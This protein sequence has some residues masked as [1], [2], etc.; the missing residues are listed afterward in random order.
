MYAAWTRGDDAGT[1]ACRDARI[2]EIV[3]RDLGFEGSASRGQNRVDQAHTGTCHTGSFGAAEH[4]AAH[5]SY[6]SGSTSDACAADRDGPVYAGQ[7][8]FA[9]FNVALSGTFDRRWAVVRF[10]G[11]MYSGSRLE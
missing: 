11:V 2:T 5:R 6:I 9:G 1:G 7:S 10:T 4:Y 8:H 3:R